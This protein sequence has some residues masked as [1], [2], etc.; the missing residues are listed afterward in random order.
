MGTYSGG[1]GP[2]LA[3]SSVAADPAGFTSVVRDGA[4]RQRGMGSFENLT[5][6]EIEGL[7]HYIRQAARERLQAQ[8]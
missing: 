5:P 8:K 6:A 7:Y 2:D 3:K 4:L 1:A